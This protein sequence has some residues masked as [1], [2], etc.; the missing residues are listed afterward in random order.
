MLRLNFNSPLF[1]ISVGQT[2]LSRPAGRLLRNPDL[3]SERVRLY[4][5][6]HNTHARGRKLTVLSDHM[7]SGEL[8]EIIL[9]TQGSQNFKIPGSPSGRYSSDFGSDVHAWCE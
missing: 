7:F 6:T 1:E 4:R 5:V 8:I 2:F 9:R 3:E